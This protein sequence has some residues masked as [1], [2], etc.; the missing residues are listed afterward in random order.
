MW[1]RIVRV[2]TWIYDNVGA[3]CCEASERFLATL[4]EVAYRASDLRRK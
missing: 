1:S 2:C 4:D 3:A